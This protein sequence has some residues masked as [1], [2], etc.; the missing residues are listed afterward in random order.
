MDPSV[1]GP[2]FF[3][4]GEF[5]PAREI[6]INPSKPAPYYRSSTACIR[7]SVTS[8]PCARSRLLRL[9]FLTSVSRIFLHLRWHSTVAN[10]AL[11]SDESGDLR[12]SVNRDSFFPDGYSAIA[13]AQA[14]NVCIRSDRTTL[15]SATGWNLTIRHLAAEWFI[16]RYFLSRRGRIEGSRYLRESNPPGDRPAAI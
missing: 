12:A 13:R 2:L 16:S 9:F 15:T 1:V 11:F 8:P 7:R 5:F 4:S 3:I 14:C 10:D 6:R